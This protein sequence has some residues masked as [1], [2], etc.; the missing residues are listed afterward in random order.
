M[1]QHPIL[2]S[3]EGRREQRE[4]KKKG[5]RKGEKARLKKVVGRNARRKE[6]DMRIRGKG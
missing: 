5:K 1:Y 6:E 4:G 3:E 2:R